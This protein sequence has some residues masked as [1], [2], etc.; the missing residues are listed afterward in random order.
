ME[1][2]C[3]SFK[4]VQESNTAKYQ[5]PV[6]W[7]KTSAGWEANPELVTE[8]T[9]A[10]YDNTPSAEEMFASIPGNDRYRKGGRGEFNDRKRHSDTVETVKKNDRGS[11]VNSGPHPLKSQE[12][13]MYL[14]PD[15]DSFMRPKVTS[16][17]TPR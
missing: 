15:R 7:I 11:S 13:P 1:G 6:E 4:G 3:D 12:R 9:N 14:T 16:F 8:L 17:L 2:T 10:I 5:V